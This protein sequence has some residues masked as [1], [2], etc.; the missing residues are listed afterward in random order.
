MT[1]TME[2]KLQVLFGIDAG[3]SLTKIAQEL[4]VGKQTFSD[5]KN[6]LVF[7]PKY[8]FIEVIFTIKT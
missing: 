8:S 6:C 1:V 4:W 7:Y 5:L 3:I 2:Q